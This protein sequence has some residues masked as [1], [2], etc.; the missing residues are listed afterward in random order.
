[1]PAWACGLRRNATC[2]IRGSVRSATYRPCPVRK[3]ASSTRRTGAPISGIGGTARPAPSEGGVLWVGPR[4]GATWLRSACRLSFHRR[5]AHLPRG[6]LDGTDDAVV[7]GAATEDGGDALSDLRLRG[8][9]IRSE[10]IERR[11]EHARR[12]EPALETMVL[13]ERLLERVAL[14]VA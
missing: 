2:S 9:R 5:S 1:M 4:R 6:G 14:A 13:A 12:A 3:R 10:K 11:H 8:R 7:A